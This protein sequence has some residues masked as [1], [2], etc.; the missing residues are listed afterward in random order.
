MSGDH[1]QFD[2]GAQ[3]GHAFLAKPFPLA[4]LIRLLAEVLAETG[5]D[6]ERSR[7]AVTA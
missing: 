3:S 7:D 5:A 4:D 2:R 6:C 1:A